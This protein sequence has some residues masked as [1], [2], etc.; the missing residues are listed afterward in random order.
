[1]EDVSV[2][3]EGERVAAVHG[4]D[5]RVPEGQFVIVL[6]PNGAG[7]TTL[8]EAINGMLPATGGH[9]SVLGMDV[10]R[11]GRHVRKRCG[12]VI[13]NFSL[14]PL[15][16]F[17]TRD[18]VMMARAARIGVLRF[19]ERRDRE[20]VDDALEAVGMTHLADRPVGKLSGGEFQKV[21]IARAMAQDPDVLL[22]D[23]PYANLD[24]DARRDI[25]AVVEEWRRRK[26]LTVVMV[27]HDIANVP[28]S[29]DRIVVIHKGRVIMDGSRDEVL[30]SPDLGRMFGAWGGRDG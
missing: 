3:Y 25:Q 26:G 11:Q 16:P 27:S 9:A 12:Y 18:V 6:G 7:K 20:A 15:D 2:V 17:I 13:Q 19:A 4:V 8:L 5:L 24:I 28:P 10:A 22:L 14:D 1:M 30:A 23:E 21:L 29:C